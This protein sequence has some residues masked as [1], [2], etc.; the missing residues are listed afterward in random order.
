MGM[1]ARALIIIMLLQLSTERG[2]VALSLALPVPTYSVYVDWI[3][4][5]AKLRCQRRRTCWS[6]GNDQTVE[7]VS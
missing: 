4:A 1:G 7:V 5:L 2:S 3:V 6:L